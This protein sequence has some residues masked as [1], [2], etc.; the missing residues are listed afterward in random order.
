MGG[1]HAVAQRGPGGVLLQPLRQMAADGR[2]GLELPLRQR[3]GPGVAVVHG[4]QAVLQ[5]RRVAQA[6]PAVCAGMC[7]RQAQGAAAAARH[8]LCKARLALRAQRLRGPAA[9]GQA[10]AGNAGG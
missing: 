1:A 2:L 7:I 4:D 10:L 5:H 6:L 9:A 8:M 3:Q